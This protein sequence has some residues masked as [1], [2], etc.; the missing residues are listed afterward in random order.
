MHATVASAQTTPAAS[1]ANQ[2]SCSGFTNYWYSPVICTGR[3]IGVVIATLLIQLT[4]WLLEVSG[5]LFNWIMNYTVVE[6]GTFFSGGVKQGVEIAWTV[7]RDIA[8]ILI[9]GIF[10][11]IA[12]SIIIGLKEFGQKKM[13]ARVLIIAVLINFSLLFT[14][15]IIDASNFTAKQL[16]EATG[17]GGN[18]QNSQVA[19]IGATLGAEDVSYKFTNAGV[20]GS[21]I[22]LM[23]VTSGA[24]TFKTL[25]AG[26]DALNNGWMAFLHGIFSSTLFLAAALV[27]LYGS[28]LLISRAVLIIF[29]MITASA[30]FASYLI[31]AWET[32]SYGWKT[33]WSSLLRS[34]V[35]APLLMLF[36]WVTVSIA[37]AMRPHGGTLG[38]LLSEPTKAVNLESLFIYLMVLGLLFASFKFSSIWAGKIGGFNIS[39]MA[40]AL[41]FTMGARFIAAPLLRQTA[42]F[43]ASKYRNTRIGQAKEI[44]KLASLKRAQ[45][46]RAFDE[47][48]PMAAKYGAEARKLEESAALKLKQATRFGI[49]KIADSKM[50]LMD[51]TA[52]KAAT[53]AAGISGFV[54]GESTR[55]TKGYDSQVKARTEA[56]EKLAAKV[57]PSADDNENAREKARRIEQQKRELGLQQLEAARRSEKTNAENI[58]QMQQLPQKLAAAQQNADIVKDRV[59]QEKIRI[60]ANTSLTPDQQKSQMRDEDN[61]IKEAQANVKIIE[62]GVAEAERPWKEA[63]RQLKDYEEETKRLAEGAAETIVAAMGKSG[64]NIAEKIGQKSG[65]IFERALGRATGANEVIGQETKKLYKNK[66]RTKSLRDVMADIQADSPAATPPPATP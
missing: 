34:A 36:L 26:A 53:K 42:G 2:I 46:A 32:S 9:I 50:N 52:M 33:W 16:Y 14:K 51:T 60:A 7:F 17:I 27:L 54:A 38:G 39:Q 15:M 47:M 48:S 20:A 8:N 3:L 66:I 64:E 31:P 13:I 43:V 11:F 23:G 18:T 65:N 1:A 62:N 12:I 28:F 55:D 58:K 59:S 49:G 35:F 6:F 5:L 40:T 44:N 21:F 56:A 25:D 63:E 30:A 22:S 24:Q 45:E 61:R 4:A 29:L 57:A 10:T 41:P 19:A 37:K